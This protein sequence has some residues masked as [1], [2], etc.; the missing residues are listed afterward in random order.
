M[1]KSGVMRWYVDAAFAD[2]NNMN[3]HTGAS[4]TI[5]TGIAYSQSN[6][7]KINTKITTEAE[8]IGLYEHI[9]N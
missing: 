1:D 5:E 6:K 4:M 2:Y 3:S 8:L 9:G 7:Q